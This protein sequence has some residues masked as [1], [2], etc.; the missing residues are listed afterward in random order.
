M[1]SIGIYEAKSRFSALVEMVEQGEEVRIT[2]HG[3]EVVRMLP[4]RRKPVITDEQIA[5]ELEQ[6]LAL[7]QTVKAQTPGTGA[8]DS[9]I[10]LRHA[11]RSQA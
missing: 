7:Q 10:A 3:K 11:G 4:M 9:V 1:Q 8:A 2:R 5:R 6:I